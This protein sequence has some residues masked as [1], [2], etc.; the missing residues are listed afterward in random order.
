MG[1]KNFGLVRLPI[2]AIAVWL[3]VNLRHTSSATSCSSCST[4]KQREARS[5]AR[6]SVDNPVRTITSRRRF[7]ARARTCDRMTHR[8]ITVASGS[9]KLIRRPS[10][11]LI[12]ISGPRVLTQVMRSRSWLCHKNVAVAVIVRT[13]LSTLI[14]AGLR[15]LTLLAVEQLEQLVADDGVEGDDQPDGDRLDRQIAPGPILKPIIAS[16]R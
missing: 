8:E 14:G 10:C 11:C 9:R 15:A 6:L 2:E 3:V 5:P 7:C 1:L 12:A 4:A 13:G 16:E